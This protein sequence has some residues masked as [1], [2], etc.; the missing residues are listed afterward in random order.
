MALTRVAGDLY[1]DIDGQL[2]EIKRQLRQ[3]EGYPY[4][5]MQLVE[6]LQAAIEGN[7]VNRHGQPF[8]SGGKMIVG[9]PKIIPIDRTQPFDPVKSLGQGWTIDEQDER[10]LAL[11]QV[12]LANVRLE[13]MLKKDESWIKGEE[14]LKRLKKAGHIRLDAKVFQT[15]WENK[16]LIPEAWK[17]KIDGNTTFIFFDGTILRNPDGRR[18]VLGLYWDGG[19]W[20]WR[21]YWLGRG[22]DVGSPSAVLASI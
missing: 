15:F 8:S 3:K 14:K 2:M 11:N 20:D 1:V 7:L 12:D 9:E 17:Q 21:Y 6:H 19:R 5:P 18:C 22:W 10:S 16:A 13:Y 4:D